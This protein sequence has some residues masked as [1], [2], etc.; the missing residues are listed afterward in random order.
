M[1]GGITGVQ[2]AKGKVERTSTGALHVIVSQATTLAAGDGVS[3]RANDSIRL[4]LNSHTNHSYYIGCWMK[5]TRP[6]ASPSSKNLAMFEFARANTGAGLAQLQDSG[7]WGLGTGATVLGSTIPASL[8]TN[9]V[10]RASYG[11]TPGASRTVTDLVATSGSSVVTSATA[12]FQI[13]DANRTFTA[14]GF[15]ADST[16]IG[17]TNTT[18]ATISST[19]TASG[20]GL[21]ATV[22][23]PLAIPTFMHAGPTYGY[24]D[25]SSYNIALISS[26]NNV[27]P[28]WVVYSWHMCDLTVAGLTYAQADAIDL[29][30]YTKQVL[31][32]GGRYYGDTNT[33]P[34]TIP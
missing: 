1:I 27:A 20:T 24:P 13:V 3:F 5:M 30:E 21:T 18:T 11:I 9:G 26:R 34:A 32:P 14:P 33:D 17:V 25:T 23:S 15:A 16:I 6:N 29:A 2:S 31:T 10:K 22:G 28:S 7:F 12:N 8:S 19:A 4:Y